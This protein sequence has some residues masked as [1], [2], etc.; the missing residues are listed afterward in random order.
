MDLPTNVNVNEGQSESLT[1]NNPTK[2]GFEYENGEEGET[3]EEVAAESTN[4][5]EKSSMCEPDDSLIT[6]DDMTSADYYFDSYSHFGKWF[7]FVVPHKL[8][9]FLFYLALL[10]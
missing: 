3:L 9:A 1:T 5:Q 2:I 6:R 4:L 7:I 8:N 10:L